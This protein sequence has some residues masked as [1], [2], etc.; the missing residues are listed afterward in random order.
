MFKSSLALY[1]HADGET[2]NLKILD[3]TAKRA[4]NH[5]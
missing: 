3:K 2:N 1:W 5:L 4:I